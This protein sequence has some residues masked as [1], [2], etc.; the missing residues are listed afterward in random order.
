MFQW[1][2]QQTISNHNL[3]CFRNLRALLKHNSLQI[4]VSCS[5]KK[6]CFQCESSFNVIMMK[7]FQKCLP[8]WE[9]CGEFTFWNFGNW[10]RI[11]EA[12][13][14]VISSKKL[15]SRGSLFNTLAV[16]M[17]TY[18]FFN[19]TIFWN[20]FVNLT[21]FSCYYTCTKCQRPILLL[22]PNNIWC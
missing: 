8:K 22:D 16:A 15:F 3:S 7:L 1:L 13:Y 2:L 12:R 10:I 11:M 6:S 4:Q 14:K 17:Y 21:T 5:K 9:M 18:D 19:L 20:N